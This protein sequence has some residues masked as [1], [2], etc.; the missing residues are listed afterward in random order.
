M[1]T[2]ELVVGGILILV[3]AVSISWPQGTQVPRIGDTLAGVSA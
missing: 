3:S 1:L 2:R